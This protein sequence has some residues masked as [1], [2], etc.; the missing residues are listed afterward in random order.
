MEQII[1]TTIL[2]SDILHIKWVSEGSKQDIS[3]NKR[4]KVVKSAIKFN[5]LNVV[6]T[7]A[8]NELFNTQGNLDDSEN[9]CSVLSLCLKLGRIEMFEVLVKGKLYFDTMD[10]LF[11]DSA[12]NY[13][14]FM[15]MDKRFN[16]NFNG[17]RVTDLCSVSWWNENLINSALENE[18]KRVYEF[19]MKN[20]CD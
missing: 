13:E 18:D 17:E 2:N 1:S 14:S 9:C 5:E 7:L 19:L 6:K 20:H 4:I 16:I 11:C 8:T 10:Q 3:I 15:Y 12:L